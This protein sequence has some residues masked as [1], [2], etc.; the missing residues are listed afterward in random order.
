[1]RYLKI[2]LVIVGTFGFIV[3]NFGNKTTVAKSELDLTKLASILQDEDILIIE[4]SLHAREKM[5]NLQSADDVKK[6][7]NELRTLFPDWEWT[8]NSSAK[9]SETMAVL[10][11]DAQ[12]ETIK[13][14]STP[15]NRNVQTYVIYE[16]KG[17][18]W[19][20]ESEKKI[21]SLLGS[22]ISDIF[23]ENTTIFSCLKGEF[24]D[25]I[26]KTL[27][28]EINHL[29]AVFRAKEIEALNEDNFISASAYSTLFGNV[30]KT[31]SEDMN[32]Q[33]G[34]R[35]HGLG[36]KTTVVVG[37]PIITIEY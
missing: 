17:N 5:E 24:S 37:T 21:T 1:M 7:T 3:L 22:R 27:P 12:K 8:T 23:H 10:D 30:L 28:E 13:I 26:D 25:K 2:F 29:L 34:I 36:E 9:H 35:N 19:K 33:I 31:N 15:I 4:W 6:F 18:S 11:T 32:L 20:A 16:V 14:V